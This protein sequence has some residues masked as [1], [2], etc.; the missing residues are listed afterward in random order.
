MKLYKRKG[1]PIWHLRQGNQRLSLHTT[2]KAYALE[3][4]EEYQAKRLGV[5]R[6]VHKR[7][8][9]YFEPYLAHCRKYN[10]VTT[11]G[12]KK[13][14][15]NYFKEQAGDPWLRQI[16]KKLIENYLDSR[17]ATRS[18]TPIS[19][20]R[21]NS[22]RQILNNFFNY[23]IKEEKV[24]KDNPATGIEKKKIVKNKK[25]KSLSRVVRRS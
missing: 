23:L 11:I 22:E 8:S 16:N 5:Y 6:V 4:L 20:E 24:C 2:R 7:A 9:E 3:L 17:V 18:K 15:L 12:D 21:F 14:T 19:T 25:P 10:K 1:S 13:R